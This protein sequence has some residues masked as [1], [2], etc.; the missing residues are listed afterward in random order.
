MP[1]YL[2]TLKKMVVSK[3]DA[4][5]RKPAWL[6][7]KSGVTKA[8]LSR[9]LSGETSPSLDTIIAIAKALDMSPT[10]LLNPMLTGDEITPEFVDYRRGRAK[11]NLETASEDDHRR[12][13]RSDRVTH[14]GK[15]KGV[16]AKEPSQQRP[17]IFA[18]YANI[19]QP[20]LDALAEWDSDWGIFYETLGLELPDAME[21]A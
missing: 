4:M 13:S 11:A 14:Q 10:E 7:E 9:F 12:S 16:K 21:K 20:I 2:N 17:N 3:L 1:K 19:P 8:T 15:T 18:R 5:D 6:A